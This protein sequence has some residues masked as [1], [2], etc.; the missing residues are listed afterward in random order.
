MVDSVKRLALKL[1]AQV[2]R[3]DGP[4]SN[5]LSEATH[6]GIVADRVAAALIPEFEL[7]QRLLETV[8]VKERLDLLA[9]A[10]DRLLSMLKDKNDQE[11]GT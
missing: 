8:D 11:S 1:V 4:L 7:R 5:A 2:G 10:L 6:A 3:D 9:E